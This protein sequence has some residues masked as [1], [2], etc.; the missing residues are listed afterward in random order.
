MPTPP[1]KQA[2]GRAGGA[3]QGGPGGG[4]PPG[5]PRLRTREAILASSRC[6]RPFP[7][8]RGWGEGGDLGLSEARP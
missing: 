2:G 3:S 5:S 1:T 6:P 4:T 8:L 7:S